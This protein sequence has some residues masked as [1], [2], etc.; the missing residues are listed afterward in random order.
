MQ[1]A[2]F[3]ILA[4]VNCYL[5][6]GKSARNVILRNAMVVGCAGKKQ[7]KTLFEPPLARDTD[8]MTSHEAA[9]KM[10]KSGALSRQEQEVYSEIVLYE[11]RI[12]NLRPYPENKGVTAKE[13]ANWSG[14]NYWMIQRRLSGLRNKGKIE[15]LAKDGTKWVEGKKQMIRD[16]SCAWRLV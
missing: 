8:P 7:M 10:V 13:I 1:L 9:E 6:G 14:L 16:N 4:A 2:G 11:E 3:V 5:G 15:R 12:R